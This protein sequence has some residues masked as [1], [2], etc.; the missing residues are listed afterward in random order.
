MHWVAPS[1]KDVL[2]ETLKKNRLWNSAARF[3]VNAVDTSVH[4]DVRRH[5]EAHPR[6]CLEGTTTGD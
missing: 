5:S 4:V 2:T 1:E 6:T 3:C